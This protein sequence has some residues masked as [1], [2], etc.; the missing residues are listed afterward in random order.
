MKLRANNQ[1]MPS[2]LES[3]DVFPLLGID[4]SR[5]RSGGTNFPIHN[6]ASVTIFYIYIYYFS[7]FMCKLKTQADGHSPTDT[8]I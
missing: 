3:M 4:S 5:F 7:L 8:D 1:A 2:R 6:R